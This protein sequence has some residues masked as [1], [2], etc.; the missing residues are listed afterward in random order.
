M[1]YFRNLGIIAIACFSFFYT[2]KIAN[3]TLENNEIYKNI[4]EEASKYEVGFVNAEVDDLYVTP[5]LNGKTVNLKDSYYNMK[6]I[7]LFNS[8]YLVFDKTYP[9][10]SIANNKDKI[11]K[12]GNSEKRSVSFIL[13]YNEEM[14]NFFKNNGYDASILVDVNTF[15]KDEELEQLNNES[16]NFNNLETLINKYSKNA[17]A[18]YITPSNEDVCRKNKKYLVKSEKVINDMTFKNIRMNIESGDIYYVTKNTNVKSMQI[19]INSILYK[20]LD[21]VRLSELLSEERDWF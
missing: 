10:I 9:K 4:K 17:Q 12:K 5:G 18:C 2:E 20:D 15:R 11:I 6:D 7:N 16:K 19:L 14:I 3:L 8:Y 13:E 1:K 21:I